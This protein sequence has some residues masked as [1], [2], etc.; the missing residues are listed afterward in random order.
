MRCTRVVLEAFGVHGI[1][2]T[3]AAEMLF[4]LR[5]AGYR[6]RPLEDRTL[7]QKPLSVVV[8]RLE[9]RGGS[10]YL[11]TRDHVMALVDEVLVDSAKRGLDNRVVVGVVEVET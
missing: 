9:R 4:A 10:Y 6:P 2:A 8:P 7:L 11:F 3:T 5:E 1:R